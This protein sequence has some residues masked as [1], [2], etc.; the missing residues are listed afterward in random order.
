MTIYSS[1]RSMAPLTTALPVLKRLPCVNIVIIIIYKQMTLPK[2]TVSL[3]Q[4]LVFTHNQTIAL[5]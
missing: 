2:C 3:F 1:F 4:S 5:G